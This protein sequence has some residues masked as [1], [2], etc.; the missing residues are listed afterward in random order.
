MFL[1][2]RLN[3]RKKKSP[4]IVVYLRTSDAYYSQC[5]VAVHAM[6]LAQRAMKLPRV[7]LCGARILSFFSACFSTVFS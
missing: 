6:P 3:K 5:V 4:F 2:T 1:N 7:V